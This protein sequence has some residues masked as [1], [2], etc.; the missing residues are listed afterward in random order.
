MQ[1][2]HSD[3]SGEVQ[4]SLSTWESTHKLLDEITFAVV[5]T[6]TT[7]LRPGPDR[8]IELAVVCVRGGEVIETFQSLV[9]PGRRIS[10]FI[11]N[12][13]GITPEMLSGA[14]TT[15]EI[16]PGFLQRIDGTILVCHNLSF[17]LNFLSHEAQLLGK[18]FP[19]GGF[20]TI[21]LARRFLPGLKR[22][23][24]D[25]VAA[26]L[27]I[28]ASNRHRALGDAE[29]TAIVF[30]RLLELARRQGI[31]TLAHL[32]RR[33]QLPVAWSGDITQGA[34]SGKGTATSSGKRA[35]IYTR[36]FQAKILRDKPLEG[37]VER[38]KA[39]C[40][41]WGYSIDKDQI[42]YE[43]QSDGDEQG[44]PELY[45]LL[46]A[47]K[48]GC[49]DVVV[50][51][52]PGRLSSSPAELITIIQ[53]FQHVG[54]KVETTEPSFLDRPKVAER[55]Q[56]KNAV[57]YR[58]K[59]RSKWTEY[60]MVG[61]PTIQQQ[62]GQ[63]R[64]AIYAKGDTNS[65][66]EQIKRC[67]AYCTSNGYSVDKDQLYSEARAS[68]DEQDRPELNPELNRLTEVAKNGLLDVVVLTN[69]QM[70]TRRPSY[71]AA[72]LQVFQDAGVQVETIE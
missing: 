51:T 41:T 9:N 67:K 5:D 24:L 17:D 32:R 28:P 58:Q 49:I 43:V 37:E 63:K 34:L 35:A 29:I 55:D 44:Q 56:M 14:P 4:S 13:T 36:S 48:S 65:R 1:T 23:K 25:M 39:Y 71:L 59:K 19:L 52:G 45:R 62:N 21:P 42:Y 6:E 20:D 61:A 22:F 7:G 46:T 68:T 33:L 18:T 10:P 72:I 8:V 27:Q 11:V 53:Q 38:C 69:V 66:Q 70:F 64:V 2:G 54:V 30:L 50:I 57:P 40:A 3:P 60:E 16:M 15:K 26:Y 12:F 47:A 31:S